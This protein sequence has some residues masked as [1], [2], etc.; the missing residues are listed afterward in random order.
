MLIFSCLN[1]LLWLL[2]L[3]FCFVLINPTYATCSFFDDSVALYTMHLERQFHS[4]G[5][6]DGCLQLHVFQ[7]GSM[8]FLSFIIIALRALIIG[9]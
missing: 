8:I 2:Y 4:S 6:L 9:N 7:L 5:H 1:D 3:S